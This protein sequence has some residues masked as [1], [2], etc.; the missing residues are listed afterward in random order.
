MKT[1]CETCGGLFVFATIFCPLCFCPVAQ[2]GP[3]FEGWTA[4]NEDGNEENSIESQPYT[5]GSQEAALW[6][7]GFRSMPTALEFETRD[8]G[9]NPSYPGG[10][11]G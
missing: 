2:S 4:C 3:Y 8:T 5:G 6:L 11:P 9:D 1:P 10:F 7:F